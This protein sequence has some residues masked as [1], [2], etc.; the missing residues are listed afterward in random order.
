MFATRL[1][2]NANHEPRS[3]F[4]SRAP[5]F[6]SRIG[7]VVSSGVFGSPFSVNWAGLYMSLTLNR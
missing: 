2:F 5:L 7:V 1:T 3:D 4:Q 6:I